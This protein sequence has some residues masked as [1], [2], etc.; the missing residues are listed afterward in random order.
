VSDISKK[1]L[2]IDPDGSPSDSEIVTPRASEKSDNEVFPAFVHR[3]SSNFVP[4]S[5]DS[6]SGR[7]VIWVGLILAVLW[8]GLSAAFLF[9]QPSEGAYFSS[10]TGLIVS[11]LVIL[12]P[13]LLVLLFC[14]ASYK[15]SRMSARASNLSLISQQLLQADQTS[16][17]LATNLA[18][19]IR[20]QMNQLDEQMSD[21]TSRFETLRH[22]AQ[23]HSKSLSDSSASL[24]ST[25]ETLEKGLNAQRKSLDAMIS[26][27]EEK[28]H[29]TQE[30]LEGQKTSLSETLERSAFS[31]NEAGQKLEDKSQAFE[32]FISESERRLSS[33]TETLSTSKREAGEVIE[34]LSGQISALTEKVSDLQTENMRL[35]EALENKLSLLSSL[36]D[37]ANDAKEELF[38]V[39]SKSVDATDALRSDAKSVSDLLSEKFQTL[40]RELS[41]SQKATRE[42]VKIREASTLAELE[43]S[44]QA[45]SELEARL[46]RL[47]KKSVEI[48]LQQKQT[49]QTSD[50]SL[51][52]DRL[53]LRPLEEEQTSPQSDPNSFDLEIEPLDLDSDMS[54]P[55]SEA[56]E[57]RLTD[58]SPDVIKPLT[59]PAPLF[60]RGKPKEKTPWRWRDM[61]GGF[62]NPDEESASEENLT[63]ESKQSAEESSSPSSFENWIEKTAIDKNRLA[64]ST[65]IETARA[66]AMRTETVSSV[67]W[68][69]E[70]G[71]AEEVSSIAK[72]HE[73]F[74]EAAR[75]YQI[76][77]SE[78]INPEIMNQEALRNRLNTPD[79]KLFILSY[80][81]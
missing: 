38:G 69:C 1:I 2:S 67:I 11:G 23:S 63:V 14:I 76:E 29:Q 64:A 36:T 59:E 33:M 17:Q 52:R 39:I 70:P 60:G 10:P 73:G 53:H 62:E 58:S 4:N 7:W 65:L 37:S 31:L 72:S 18:E 26:S 49:A 78:E 75:L 80:L 20:A 47:N 44:Q 22:E 50:E 25:N 54:I 30:K 40:N 57:P 15:L 48:E 16:A 9:L 27:V 71:L 56:Q 21:L 8:I 5:E 79:G 68:R 35:S 41:D 77:K 19:T 81:A 32:G 42:T 66:M 6:K 43:K 74:A 51:S 46:K 13:A 3:P 24:L 61:M 45:L 12:F 55:S 28:F 34:G